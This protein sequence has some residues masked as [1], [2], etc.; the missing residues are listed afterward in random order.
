MEA[1]AR[2][3]TAITPAAP[4]V[5]Q[6][7]LKAR[8]LQVAGMVT[9]LKFLTFFSKH[10]QRLSIILEAMSVRCATITISK[11]KGFYVY[12]YVY[13]NINIKISHIPDV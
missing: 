5:A 8:L 3:K 9:G 10:S 4:R 13:V 1:V 7:H 2:A 12:F 6:V 11:C